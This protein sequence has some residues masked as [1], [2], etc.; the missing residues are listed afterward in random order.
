M[1][2][3]TW[4]ARAGA[5]RRDEFLDAVG[6]VLVLVVAGDELR[7][8]RLRQ[9]GAV[10]IERVGLEREAPGQQIGLLAILDLASL[11]MLMVLEIAPEMKGCAAAIMRICNSTER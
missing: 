11:G 9:L 5:V 1:R 2:S 10:A 3:A 7:G 6:R 4:A 8:Q